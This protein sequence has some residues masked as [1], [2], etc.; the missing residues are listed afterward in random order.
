MVLGQWINVNIGEIPSAAICDEIH[1]QEEDGQVLEYIGDQEEYPSKRC[2][3]LKWI[4]DIVGCQD[5]RNGQK[6]GYSVTV[7]L[8]STSSVPSTSRNTAMNSDHNA[9]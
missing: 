2:T 7:D 3:I 8:R 6:D 1:Q 5:K 9:N 4:F